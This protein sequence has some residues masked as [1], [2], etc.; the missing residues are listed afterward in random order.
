MERT[1]QDLYLT[2]LKNTLSFSLWN[3]PPLPLE[4][5]NHMRRFPKRAIVSALA[6]VFNLAG[7][8]VVRRMN[9][10][11]S[12][13]T[14]GKTWPLYAHTM[15]GMKRLD[16]LQY[17][18]QSVI[19]NKVEGDLIETGV[20]RGGAC[21]LMR[22]ILAAYGITDRRVFVADSFAGLPEPDLGKYP[23]DIGDKRHTVE[24][25]A[26]SLDEVKSN[27]AKYDLLDDQVV[28]LQGWFA[29]TLPVAPVD[30]VAV[31]RLDGD[32]YGSTMDAL[33]NLYPKLSTGG[34]CII[35]DYGLKNPSCKQAVDDYRAEQNIKDPLVQI[36]WVGVYWQKTGSS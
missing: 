31:M 32:M 22:A 3:E 23:Q 35:D 14:E 27:F 34:F 20:W 6:A 33:V 12:A 1:P 19:D 24:F 9:T 11:E 28:F 36:D 30:K 15:I 8:Q 13:R 4:M 16:N 18:V 17:C 5:H 26:V 7:L 10:S 25:L 29:E 21:I 2:L